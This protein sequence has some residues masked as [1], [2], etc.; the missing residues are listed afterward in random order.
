[1]L[2]VTLY[3]TSGAVTALYSRPECLWLLCP[4]LMYWVS[5]LWLKTHRGEMHDDPL[6]YALKDR[7]SRVLG[8]AALAILLAAI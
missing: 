6:V 8:V 3:I 2:V 1:M 5:R 4:V 7:G